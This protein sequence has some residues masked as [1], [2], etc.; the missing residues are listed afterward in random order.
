MNNSSNLTPRYCYDSI[1]GITVITPPRVNMF[2][3]K[4]ALIFLKQNDYTAYRKFKRLVRTLFIITETG[5]QSAVFAKERIVMMEGSIFE[6]ETFDFRYISSLLIHELHHIAQYLSGHPSGGDSAETHAY[7]KQRK[8][9]KKINYLH[10]INWLDLCY[11]SNW[12]HEFYDDPNGANR[13]Q[14][15]LNQNIKWIK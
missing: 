7:V 4:M 15:F 6:D 13:F 14:T 3:L 5:Y 11:Q 2:R 1:E 12:W 8:Y 10:A 9:L